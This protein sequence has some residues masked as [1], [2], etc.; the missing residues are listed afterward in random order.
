M[1]AFVMHT[2]SSKWTVSL[3]HRT[4]FAN[5]LSIAPGTLC[6]RTG[7]DVWY[8][9]RPSHVPSPTSFWWRWTH[10]VWQDFSQYIIGCMDCTQT[11]Y[12]FWSSLV[13]FWRFDP[14]A[15]PSF[16]LLWPKS[17]SKEIQWSVFMSP[18]LAVYAVAFS[19]SLT[20]ASQPMWN[21]DW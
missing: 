3:F 12:R 2:T 9:R 8:D 1:T 6:R 19:F 18:G 13:S 16:P 15:G 4:S 14:A 21:D 5:E 7:K 20:T 17:D 10:H 11:V